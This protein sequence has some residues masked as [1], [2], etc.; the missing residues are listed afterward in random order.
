MDEPVDSI[1]PSERPERKTSFMAKGLEMM[2]KVLNLMCR[3]LYGF[4]YIGLAFLATLVVEKNYSYLSQIL[5]KED[6]FQQY[7]Q[8]YPRG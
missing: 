3:T 1:L 6:R 8:I 5:S 2:F 4:I 7:I